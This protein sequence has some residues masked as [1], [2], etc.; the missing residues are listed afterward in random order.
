MRPCRRLDTDPHPRRQSSRVGL[1]IDARYSALWKR[2]V[3]YIVAGDC[4]Q[5][6]FV[7][8]RY[9]WHV[10]QKLNLARMV[11][12]AEILSEREQNFEWMCVIEPGELRIL[13]LTMLT[14]ESLSC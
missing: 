1:D 4:N 7:W 10:K 11:G 13:R 12:A 8:A 3:Y 14:I 5:L 9:A 6:P 2:Y